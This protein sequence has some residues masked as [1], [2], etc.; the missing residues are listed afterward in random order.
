MK[1][2]I[3]PKS[4]QHNNCLW[5]YRFIS[6]EATIK[7]VSLIR[8]CYRGHKLKYYSTESIHPKYWNKETQRVKKSQEF[9]EHPEFNTQWNNIEATIQN[10]FRKYQ[11]IK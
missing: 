1:N 8:I 3:P 10:L 2:G 9:R 7:I 5:L 4:K 11:N 6:S